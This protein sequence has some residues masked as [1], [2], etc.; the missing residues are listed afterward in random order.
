MSA[1]HP[2]ITAIIDEFESARARLHRL[3]KA[4][5]ASRW[6]ERAD[7]QRWSVAECIAHLNLTS[8][9]YL[10]LLGKGISDARSAGVPVPRRYRRDPIGWALWI[11]M[12]PPV[13][14][15]RMRTL[16]LFIPSGGLPRDATV[17]EF[18][19]LQ[20]E[21]IA[22]AREANGLP[23]GAVRVQSPFD[24]RVTYNLYSCLTILPR[25]QHRHLW[26]GEG[27]WANKS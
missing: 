16:A 20:D 3:T 6:S 19:R 9:A 25:H 4:T 1:I 22:F 15:G 7:P 5:P 21:Q 12:G 17:S 24:A 13:R 2:Q 18:D 14:F 8:R 26:Q 27:I 10:P 23:L 11:A